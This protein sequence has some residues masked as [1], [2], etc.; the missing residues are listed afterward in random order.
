MLNNALKL[1]GCKLMDFDVRT[2]RGSYPV[3][4]E[5]GALKKAADMG[6]SFNVG[7]EM[8]FFLFLKSNAG[9]R[10][11]SHSRRAKRPR[12]YRP[13]QPYFRPCSAQA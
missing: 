10:G 5:R 13:G 7:P 11:F 4:V 9:T 12:T 3:Y 6:Y 8:E 2:G 1:P